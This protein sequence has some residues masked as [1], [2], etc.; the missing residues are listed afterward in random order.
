MGQLLIIIL[1]YLVGIFLSVE[2][3]LHIGLRCPQ[4]FLSGLKICKRLKGR[5]RTTTGYSQ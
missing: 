3:I 1:K 4:L 5:C 2:K